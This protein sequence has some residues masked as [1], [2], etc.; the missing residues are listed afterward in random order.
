MSAVALCDIDILSVLSASS[1]QLTGACSHSP[2]NDDDSCS[3]WCL[4][5]F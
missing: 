4:Q 3:L 1:D 5:W 2:L